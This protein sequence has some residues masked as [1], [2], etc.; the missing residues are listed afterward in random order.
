MTASRED[1]IDNQ[2]WILVYQSNHIWLSIPSSLLAII[3]TILLAKFTR[4]KC[5][6]KK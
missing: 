2:L 3:I 5:T 4:E 6:V 1:D